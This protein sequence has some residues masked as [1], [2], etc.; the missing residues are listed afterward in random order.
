M[1]I[2][3]PA[4]L[5]KMID[6][7]A[8]YVLL[9][10]R[11][12]KVAAKGHIK[13]AYA[14]SM[15]E[16][17]AMKDSLPKDM[18]APVIIYAESDQAAADAFNAVRGW[19]YKNA[20]ILSGGIVQWTK[21][22][23]PVQKNQLATKLEYVKRLKPG[24]IAISEFKQIAES[25]PADKVILDVREG[26]VAGVIKGA[27]PIPRGE[28]ETRVAELPKD[29]EIV[30]HCNTGVLAK[31]A[32]DT[33]TQKGLSKVRYLNAVIQVSPDRTYEITEK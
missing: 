5:K 4:G 33:L 12:V 9:D 11:G 14:T 21:E 1:V 26:A 7:D 6:E 24:E 23:N 30:I 29:K 27:I 19:G 8:S 15:Q 32:Y 13:G 28:L 10:L 25:H 2:S 3:E 17:A 31:M 16:L 20:S 18:S 22:N